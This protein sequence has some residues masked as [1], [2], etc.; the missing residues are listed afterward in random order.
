[1]LDQTKQTDLRRRAEKVLQEQAEEQKKLSSEDVKSL[2]HELRTHQIE[3]E[4]QNEE[5]RRA[6]SELEESRNRYADLYNFA[7]IGYFTF[8]TKGGILEANLTGALMLD[9]NKAY[10]IRV[11]FFLYI[12][13]SDRSAYYSHLRQVFKTRTKQACELKLMDSKKN[14][15]DA[16]LESIAVQDSGGNCSRCRTAVIDITEL[17][18]AEQAKQ[19]A[20]KYAENIVETLRES[21][22]VLDSELRVKRVNQTFYKTFNVTPEETLGKLI[23]ELGN[24]QWDI[25]ELRELL[26][27]I[28]SRNTQFNDFE[29]DHKFPVIGRKIMLLNARQF[30]KSDTSAQLILLAI[31]DITEKKKLETQLLRSQRMESIGV[32]SSGV[33]HN[34]NNML[35]PI[36]MSVRMLKEKLKD[37]QSQKLLTILEQNSRRGADL[38]KQVLSFSRGVEGERDP[39]AVAYLLSEIEKIIKDTFPKDITI[40]I[41]IQKDLSTIVGDAAQLHQVLMNLCVNAKDAMPDGG[42][43]S[44]TASDFLIDED[45]ARVNMDARAGYYVV[46][47]VKDTG[48]GIPSSILDRIFEPFFTRKEFGKGTGLGLSTALAIVRSHGG[49]INVESEV[50]A[51]SIF[52]VYLPAIKIEIKGAEEQQP[53]FPEGHGE[54]I[55]VAE[56]EAPVRE[57]TT[58]TLEAYGYKVLTADNGAE[59]VALYA[60]NKDKIK[61]VLM[62][63]MMPVMDGQTSI[64]AIRRINPLVEIIAVSGLAEKDKLANITDHVYAFLSKPYTAEKLL[65]KVYETLKY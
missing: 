64:R 8:D 27:E 61:V 17:K 28:I 47:T 43:L 55:L 14:Q 31:E 57:I 11:P 38:I 37:E 52:R 41:D 39:L 26:E 29:V 1:M 22:V 10:L 35:T 12:A 34:L 3:L 42:I 18:R 4:M 65:K 13:P 21:L 23:Y 33:A 30:Y 25:P 51:G 54:Y 53:E 6:Q 9:M 20:Y 15:F 32:L 59:A 60:Q 44:I 46:I 49:F 16:R 48:A 58:A 19:E 50:G 36:M 24:S 7:P 40:Q 63:V 5:L 62:D 2:I 45:Y 56:D